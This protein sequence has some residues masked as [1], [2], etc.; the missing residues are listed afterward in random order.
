MC[1]IMNLSP[2]FFLSII[3]FQT[4]TQLERLG[5]NVEIERYRSHYST[6][7]VGRVI[8]Q[9][10]DR[11]VV[12]SETGEH[13]AEVTGA[14]RYLA[15]SSNGFPAVGDWVAV[16]HHD[17]LDMIHAVYPR[18]NVLTRLA[19]GQYG[20]LQPVAAN[21]DLAFIVTA[22][23]HDFNINRVERFVALCLAEGIRPVVLLSKIDLADTALSDD[24]IQQ[25]HNRLPELTIIP[26]SSLNG[27][28][29]EQIRAMILPEMTCC[30][31]GSSGV[32]K[33][34]LLNRLAGAEWMKTLTISDSTQ[35]GRHM[36]THR[37]LVVLPGGGVLID[38]P[39][40]REVGISDGGDGVEQ[41]FREIADLVRQ[42]RFRDC[43]HRHEKGCAVLQALEN[44]DISRQ[45]YENYLRL[46]REKHHYQQTLHE[47]RKGNKKF[48]KMVKQV[49]K[50]KRRFDE[51]P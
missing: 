31:L 16:S 29:Y 44:G 45:A 19:V 24:M 7:D 13:L 12:A 18:K 17:E 5:Y 47:K 6:F 32:G 50:D 42:C 25:L 2:Q 48:G 51:L 34:T 4:M 9:H 26:F 3:K 36:T 33:S 28:G 20:Q 46:E 30:L 38:N 11:Y 43:T 41:T 27:T 21:L 15:E 37:E 8:V 10:R 22:V 39:G 1:Q 14:F 35:K 49:L 23:G 40:M